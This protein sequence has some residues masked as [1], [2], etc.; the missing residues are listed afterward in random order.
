MNIKTLLAIA[1]LAVAPVAGF[2][3]CSGE[4]HVMS[5]ADGTAYDAESGTCKTVTG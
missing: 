3:Q 1:A 4:R 2:A 5:C